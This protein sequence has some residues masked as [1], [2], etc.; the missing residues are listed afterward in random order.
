MSKL[1]RAAIIGIAGLIAKVGYEHYIKQ[2]RK[3]TSEKETST[4]AKI[5]A[6][7]TQAS[8]QAHLNSTNRSLKK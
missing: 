1:E 3:I 5:D 7:H 4:E 8:I 6:F 2:K